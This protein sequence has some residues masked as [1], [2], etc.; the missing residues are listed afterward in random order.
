MDVS[1]FSALVYFSPGR[2]NGPAAGRTRACHRQK[3]A[4]R[5]RC[6]RGRRGLFLSQSINSPQR[7]RRNQEFAAG[8]HLEI[9]AGPEAAAAF[10]PDHH[11]DFLSERRLA[12]EAEGRAD[13]H[14]PVLTAPG[15]LE[16]A[17]IG[18][19]VSDGRAQRDYRLE[20]NRS[21]TRRKIHFTSAQGHAGTVAVL[22]LRAIRSAMIRAPSSADI[23]KGRWGS[24]SF[25]G[26]SMK[27]G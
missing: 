20:M 24:M 17:S 25:S 13:V 1:W 18:G 23:K 6:R 19:G 27:P 4:H 21:G 7:G 26:V 2:V 15:G 16:A 11:K 14:I 5:R 22:T 8:Q 12:P 10:V 9:A 3:T